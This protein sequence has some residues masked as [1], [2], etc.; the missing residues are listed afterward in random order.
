MA[1]ALTQ[2]QRLE[3]QAAAIDSLALGLQEAEVCEQI[4]VSL[5]TFQRWREKDPEFDQACDRAIAIAGGAPALADPTQHLVASQETAR[6]RRLQADKLELEL[7]RARG[8]V[9]DRI[10]VESLLQEVVSR[11]DRMDGEANWV[12]LQ[13]IYDVP[14]DES[15]DYWVPEIKA[16]VDYINQWL[17]D[18]GA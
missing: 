5:R 18:H 16:I 7:K 12:R 13:R 10:D 8:L 15:K 14:Y 2:K 6:L 4:E 9:L 3:K 11:V 17:E 1:R